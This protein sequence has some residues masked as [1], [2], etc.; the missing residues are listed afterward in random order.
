MQCVSNRCK[1]LFEQKNYFE[2][3]CT[4]TNAAHFNL[5]SFFPCLTDR[6]DNPSSVLN[7]LAC[8]TRSSSFFVC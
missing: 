2:V 1:D 6:G 5:I 8:E 4:L 7:S 3:R